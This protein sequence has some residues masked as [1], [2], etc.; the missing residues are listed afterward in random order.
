MRFGK[1]NPQPLKKHQADMI[2]RRGKNP[3]NYMMLKD[4]YTSLYLL[5]VR[6][7]SVCILYKKSS[8]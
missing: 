6:D 8:P 1:L 5:D 4:T 7:R 3:K 2:R